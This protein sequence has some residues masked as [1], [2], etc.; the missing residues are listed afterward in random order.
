MAGINEGGRFSQPDKHT[1]EAMIRATSPPNASNDQI[2]AA[3]EKAYAAK[4][5]K[6]DNDL[7]QTGRL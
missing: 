7:F 5:A 3:V 2:N 6:R 4:V 1:I